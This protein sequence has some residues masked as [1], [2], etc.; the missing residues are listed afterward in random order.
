MY[1]LFCPNKIIVACPTSASRTK[2]T[3]SPDSNRE[4]VA[5]TKQHKDFSIITIIN[6]LIS[7]YIILFCGI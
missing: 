2:S 5:A 6:L 3:P 1:E 4:R 7:K